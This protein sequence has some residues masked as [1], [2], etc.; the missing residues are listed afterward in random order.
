MSTFRPSLIPKQPGCYLMKNGEGA[1]LYVGKA[2]DLSKRVPSYWRAKGAK[3]RALAVEI[4]DIEYV[5]TSNEVEALI[6]EAQLIARYHPKYNIDLK[7]GQRYAFLKFTNEPFPKLV[8]ARQ[9][10]KDGKYL[11]P[12]PSGAARNAAMR[13]ANNIF[14]LRTKCK[15]FSGRACLR[16]HLGVCSGSCIGEI[17][18]EGYQKSVKDAE[19]FLK[20]D[21]ASLLNRL[22]SDM[23]HA[24]KE[25][26]FEKAKLYRDEI[27][28][29]L[30]LEQQYV[31]A[32]KKYDQD[33]INYI[34][35]GERLLFQLF[36]F[37]KGIIYGR[38]EYSFDLATLQ[39]VS[40]QE[41]LTE[42]IRQYYAGHDVP[43]EVILPRKPSELQL[44][45]LYL[46]KISGHS[47]ALTTPQRGPKLKL[48]EMVKQNLLVHL[49]RGAGQLYELQQALRLPQIPY[50]IDCVDISHLGGKDT[51]GSLV[52][53][54]NGQPS[55]SGY[56]KFIIK[57]V[58]QINDF[59][60]IGEVITRFGKRIIEGKEK[61]PDLL[62]IDGG[63]GQLNSALKALKE[64]GLDL[65]T[66]GLA[67]KLEEIYVPWASIPL[68]LPP[69]SQALQVL[70][71]L[72]DEAHR[73]AITFQR[74]KRKVTR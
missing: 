52:Q 1:V 21:Y 35:Q 33:V 9:I 36:H 6:T 22:R 63:R 38:K 54:I 4:E 44:T 67:K 17:S 68:R 29:L 49:S 56:R 51:V 64:S 55:K 28:A 30:K 26:H 13:A 47:V 41:A 16:Y 34:V 73:F 25:Q 15:P 58:D 71:A 23:E 70:R 7:T 27:A 3:T 66:I 57:T 20:G 50:V 45:E 60:S 74:K 40:E 72:R 65:T 12:Y 69:K 8:I 18:Q 39:I 32:P 2:K 24:A 43:K 31:S 42:F 37:N 11:G 61:K 10:T 46:K 59:A 14:K 5:I 62:V 19:R 53:V 48:L